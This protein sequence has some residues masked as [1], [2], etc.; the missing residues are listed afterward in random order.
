MTERAT[1][2]I[3]GFLKKVKENYKGKVYTSQ[4]DIDTA[5]AHLI[6]ANIK[7]I[8]PLITEDI[9]EPAEFQK[10]FRQWDVCGDGGTDMAIWSLIGQSNFF[11][12][13][14]YET[15]CKKKDIPHTSVPRTE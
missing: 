12:E 5:L 4:E 2:F 3:E 15:F 9:K 11:R 10:C 1:E 13:Q 14:Y 7:C 8:V 6:R